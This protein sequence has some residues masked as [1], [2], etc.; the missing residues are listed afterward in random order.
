MTL[1]R[2]EGLRK[3]YPRVTALDDLT[4]T[5]E[6]GVTGLVGAK[7]AGNSTLI[8]IHLGHLDPT[9]GSAEVLGLDTSRDGLK[10]REL[11]GYM[12]EHDCLPPEMSATNFVIHMAR[13]SGLPP[14]EARE[15]TAEVL[16]HV[17]L[18]EERY[19]PIGGYSTG[20][21]Q[22]VKLAQALVHDPR[23]LF[24]DEPTNG[25]DP[26]GRD[27]M[28][29]LVRRTGTNFGISIVLSSHLLGEIE[30]VCDAIAVVEEGRLVQSGSVAALTEQ[31]DVMEFEVE[32]GA[33]EV[34]AALQAQ[35]LAAVAGGRLIGV[36]SEGTTMNVATAIV[37]VVSQLEVPLIRL[38]RRRLT[39]ESLF[40]D[41]TMPSEP[42][43]PN[44][45]SAP[46]PVAAS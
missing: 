32:W 18:F 7:G 14:S 11:V 4:L 16:R 3:Q 9:S 12:P 6:E 21:K 40:T 22:R 35:G 28:L 31:T 15:R 26:S 44:Q 33:E 25:L 29:D 41:A 23:L 19:R 20:M 36:S 34:V 43:A 17:G 13:M 39:L 1:V 42:A 37:G 10:I 27:D 30:R 38:Q 45:P 8:K 2:T 24:L 5:L 46:A